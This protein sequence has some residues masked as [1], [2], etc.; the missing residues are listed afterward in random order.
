MS[1]YRF[2]IALSFGIAL[3]HIGAIVFV[4]SC[5][6]DKE[7]TRFDFEQLTTTVGFILP[8]LTAYTM[9]SVTYIREIMYSEDKSG[10]SLN[11]AFVVMC[12]LFAVAFIGSMYWLIYDKAYNERKFEEFKWMMGALE[13]A[14]G[15]FFGQFFTSLFQFKANNANANNG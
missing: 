13:G 14:F 1:E 4:V 8:M 5:Y 15:V 11:M 9:G 6:T 3:S 12:L 2:K 10:K 7:T